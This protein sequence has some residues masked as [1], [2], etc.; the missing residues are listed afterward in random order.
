MRR[1]NVLRERMEKD[2]VCLGVGDGSE[3]Q[4]MK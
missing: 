2:L 3:M 4:L 1:Q